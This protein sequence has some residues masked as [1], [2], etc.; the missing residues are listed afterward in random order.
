[1]NDIPTIPCAKTRRSKS[2]TGG[3]SERVVIMQMVPEFRARCMGDLVF[4]TRMLQVLMVMYCLSRLQLL[5][6]GRRTL[7]RGGSRGVRQG[8]GG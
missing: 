6:R 3:E 7:L 1:M 5:R 8:S 4:G 2:V